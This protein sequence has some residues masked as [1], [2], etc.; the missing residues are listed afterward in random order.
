MWDDMSCSAV[1]TYQSLRNVRRVATSA[2][3]PTSSLEVVGLCFSTHSWPPPDAPAPPPEAPLPLLLG[4][5]D[6]PADLAPDST[7]ME[8]CDLETQ[9][10][11]C[12]LQRFRPEPP[13][14]LAQGAVAV[15]PHVQVTVCITQTCHRKRDVCAKEGCLSVGCWTARYTAGGSDSVQQEAFVCH[16]DKTGADWHY[17]AEAD[18][19][20]QFQ[21]AQDAFIW[22]GSWT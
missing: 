9:S 7:R 3:L 19:A 5:A 4:P 10:T 1:M 22:A 14:A 8:F 6:A 2:P 20:N 18:T 16:R 21:Q 15:L 12:G 11:V 13:E 17:A